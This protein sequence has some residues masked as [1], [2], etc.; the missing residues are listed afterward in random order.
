MLHLY[1][2]I[3]LTAKPFFTRSE[4]FELLQKTNFNLPYITEKG[5]I[6][7]LRDPG[8]FIFQTVTLEIFK[9]VA[10]AGRSLREGEYFNTGD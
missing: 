6:T 5:T 8:F 10:A 1:F 4:N 3:P 2:K 7:D 9:R